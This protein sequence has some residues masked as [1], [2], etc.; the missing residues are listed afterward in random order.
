MSNYSAQGSITI[1]RLRNGDSIFI[2]LELN[3]KPLYQAVDD[4]TGAVIPD[5]TVEAN[6]PVI[7]PHASTTRGNTVYLSSH[8]WTYNGVLLVFNGAT[9]GSYIIDS[10]GKFGLNT[11]NGALKIMDNLA[12]TINVAN[13][14]LVYGCVATVVGVE[15]NLTKSIDIQIAKAG[16][17]SYFG[18]INASS[19]QMDV[20]HPTI[21]LV[22]ELWLS[23]SGI[24]TYYVKWYKGNT[25]WTAKA[26]MKNITISRDDINAS[27]LFIAEFY[28]HSEDVQ[29]VF[30]AGICIID[31]LD[32]IALVPY[33][34]SENKEVSEGSPVTVSARLVRV[35]T[36]AVLT[37]VSPVWAMSIMDGDTWEEKAS[38]SSSSIQVTTEHTD[39]QDGTSHDVVVMIDCTFDSIE[40]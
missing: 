13:D 7:T 30:R 37:P 33:I 16:S 8:T 22:T 31:T 4:Q 25:E 28:L 17:S 5:W 19:T 29:Y 10:T 3:G 36:G 20:D 26:G 32:E 38:G 12:S 2:T 39:Q 21:S 14:T 27:Q 23:G 1:K 6:R 40:D 11:R 15:Y 18:F 35:S 9:S 24:S 34:S